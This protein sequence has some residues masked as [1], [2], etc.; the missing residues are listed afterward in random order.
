MDNRRIVCAA[1]RHKL[2]GRLICGPRHFDETMWC[3]IL[4]ISRAEWKRTEDDTR[5]LPPDI[6]HWSQADQGFI[7]QHGEFLTREEAWP[8]AAAA[9]QILSDQRN[10]Q[11]GCLHSEHL[12]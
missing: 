3:Q 6:A 12:Y 5:K 2:D 10:W 11:H 9:G 7:D 4:G 8:I 1:I